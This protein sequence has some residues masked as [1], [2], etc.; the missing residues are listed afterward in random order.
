MEIYFKNEIR[1]FVSTTLFQL[2]S[3]PARRRKRGQETASEITKKRGTEVIRIPALPAE[4]G[5]VAE[6]PS[7]AVAPPKRMRRGPA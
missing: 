4:D 2:L 7:S 6:L 5:G 1:N 3:Y